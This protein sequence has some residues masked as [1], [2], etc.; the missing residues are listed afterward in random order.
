MLGLAVY[1][2]RMT[3][4]TNKRLRQQQNKTDVVNSNLEEKDDENGNTK[5][6]IDTKNYPRYKEKVKV[7][8]N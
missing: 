3:T 6:E 7:L 8:K 2:M 5:N 1:G 4:K